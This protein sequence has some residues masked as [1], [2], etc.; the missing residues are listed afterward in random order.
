M[1]IA[2]LAAAAALALACLPLAACQTPGGVSA[3]TVRANTAKGLSA[4][5][6][7]VTGLADGV[8]LAACQGLLKGD[9][10]KTAKTVLQDLS[11]GLDL[12]ETGY[13]AGDA[14]ELQAGLAQLKADVAQLQGLSPKTATALQASLTAVGAAVAAFEAAYTAPAAPASS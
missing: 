4:V 1:R 14:K 5:E 6:A 2:T 10:A 9:A 8:D 13:H 3:S 12:A 11:A 7:A